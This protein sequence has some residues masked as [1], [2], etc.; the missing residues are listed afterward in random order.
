MKK[1]KSTVSTVKKQTKARNKA[2]AAVKVVQM[3]LEESNLTCEI[4]RV[5]DV[6]DSINVMVTFR[7][8]NN[9]IKFYLG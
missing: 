1:K 8:N 5:H 3:W 2:D 7:V 4:E 9:D 6:G